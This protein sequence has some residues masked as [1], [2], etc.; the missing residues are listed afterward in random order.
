MPRDI[1]EN[2]RSQWLKISKRSSKSE[3]IVAEM[4]KRNR[5]KF[6]FHQRIGKYEADFLIGKVIFEID[7]NVHDAIKTERDVF[8]ANQGYVPI[9]L[10]V[11]DKNVDM[12]AIEIII[13]DLILRNG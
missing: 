8:L 9:H 5:I 11:E 6:K 1:L 10:K 13:K 2:M 4:L 3:R 7:G 12:K